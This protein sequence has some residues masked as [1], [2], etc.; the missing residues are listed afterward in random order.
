MTGEIFNSQLAVYYKI[1][2]LTKLNTNNCIKTKKTETKKTRQIEEEYI[3]TLIIITNLKEKKKNQ[4]INMHK[5]WSIQISSLNS[6]PHRNNS[7]PNPSTPKL[8]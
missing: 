3:P 1:F 4:T 5:Y 2:F 8:L 7:N 6:P